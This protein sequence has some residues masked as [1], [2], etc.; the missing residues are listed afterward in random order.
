MVCFKV[1]L[2]YKYKCTIHQWMHFCIEGGVTHPDNKDWTVAV[3]PQQ[4]TLPPCQVR[5]NP[6]TS[7]VRAS[8]W[9]AGVL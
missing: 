9:D 8:Q 3:W 7:D 4:E 5:F 2:T 1:M 6:E